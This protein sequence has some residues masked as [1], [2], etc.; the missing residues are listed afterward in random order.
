MKNLGVQEL[1]EFRMAKIQQLGTRRYSG[2]PPPQYFSGG[3]ASLGP[4]H[5]NSELLQLLNSLNS[6]NSLS[7]HV[8]R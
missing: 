7:H 4:S 5:A 3:V 8:D 1:Q 2:A 6:S